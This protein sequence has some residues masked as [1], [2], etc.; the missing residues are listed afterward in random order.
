MEI[1]PI[2]T[3]VPKTMRNGQLGSLLLQLVTELDIVPGGVSRLM[4]RCRESGITRTGVR[5]APVSIETPKIYLGFDGF[6]TG[7]C[8]R[9]L[10][11]FMHI[12]STRHAY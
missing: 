1:S 11:H 3:S 4:G 10:L 2:S 6:D 5:F 12:R 7:A 9:S 8:Y